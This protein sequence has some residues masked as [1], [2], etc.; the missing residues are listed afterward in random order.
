MSKNFL[1]KYG[2][3]RVAIGEMMN[4]DAFDMA[5]ALSKYGLDVREIYGTVTAESF[6]A[7]APTGGDERVY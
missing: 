6:C 3:I 7:P 4:G 2:S 5:V 1:K